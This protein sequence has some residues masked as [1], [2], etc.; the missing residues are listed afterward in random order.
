MATGG[1]DYVLRLY[2]MNVAPYKVL[3]QFETSHEEEPAHFNRIYSIKFDTQDPHLVYSG[4]WDKIV[5]IFDT[6][7]NRPVAH[8]SGPYLSGGDTM[9]MKNGL[10][11]TGSYWVEDCL[12]VWDMKKLQRV[13][14]IKWDPESVKNNFGFIMS[15]RLD[16]SA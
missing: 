1:V 2:D 9:D 11:L 5:S 10:L 15:C 3:S 7:M 8:I 12:E 6:R 13:H 14:N 16:E 4:G